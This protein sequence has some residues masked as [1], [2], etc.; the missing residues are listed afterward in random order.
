MTNKQTVFAFLD[1]FTRDMLI[2]RTVELKDALVKRFELD[3]YR[4]MT[5]VMEWLARR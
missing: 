4:A 1:N 5:L 3:D 2:L